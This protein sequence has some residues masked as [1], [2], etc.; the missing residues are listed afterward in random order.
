M[1][2]N[3]TAWAFASVI[4][5]GS[6]PTRRWYCLLIAWLALSCALLPV[7]FWLAGLVMQLVFS[8]CSRWRF[9]LLSR[10]TASTSVLPLGMWGRLTMLA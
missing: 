10:I 4:A 6:E 1:T 7:L 3:S 9:A 5:V 2:L 8:C